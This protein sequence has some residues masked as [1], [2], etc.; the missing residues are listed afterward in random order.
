MV[1]SRSLHCGCS[2]DFD[3]PRNRKGESTPLSSN[4]RFVAHSPSVRDHQH[5]LKYSIQ[6]YRLVR[7]T[8]ALYESV[9]KPYIDS[10]P[11]AT[12]KWVYGILEGTAE[13]ENVLLRDDDPKIGFVLTPDLFV[14]LQ[15]TARPDV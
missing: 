8:P 13:A 10:I 6:K 9:V 4:P 15:S 3:L 5:I 12:I 11:P 14:R 1:R 7:E 2:I